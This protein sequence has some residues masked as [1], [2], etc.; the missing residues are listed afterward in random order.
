M[1]LSPRLKTV[2]DAVGKCN[3]LADVGTD[4]GYIPVYMLEEGLCNKAYASDINEGPL[5][6]AEEFIKEKG[7]SHKCETILCNGLENVPRDY[8]ALVIAGMGGETI[9]SIID[10]NSPPENAKLVL[11]PMTEE[12]TLRK[13][14]YTHGYK[15][16][17]ETGISEPGHVYVVITAQKGITESFSL[18]DLI[19]SPAFCS[20]KSEDGR[21]YIM[22]N[23]K[24]VTKVLDGLK[25]ST[26]PKTEEI[27]SAENELDLLKIIYEEIN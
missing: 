4:H 16:T 3:I 2:S 6:R 15:I 26:T 25:R 19:A 11:Q 10:A 22:K 14:L 23:I 20:K 13:Y 5:S 1:K 8:D 12:Q 21:A 27:T 18:K 7:L 9:A 17:D 24:K